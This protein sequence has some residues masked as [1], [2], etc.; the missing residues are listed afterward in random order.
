MPEIIIHE[1]S[2]EDV[3]K[4][5]LDPENFNR[6]ADDNTPPLSEFD[7]ERYFYNTPLNLTVKGAYVDGSIASI[8]IEHDGEIHFM[9]L[10]EFRP[11][12]HDIADRLLDTFSGEL[13]TKI[14]SCYPS[15]LHFTKKHGFVETGLDR[16]VFKKNGQ[17][18]DEYIL[19]RKLCQQQQH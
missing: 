5:F 1:P 12:A 7:M 2:K 6:S 19:T 4:V 15:T 9:L 17:L 13:Y 11:F 16:D 14:P 3:N 8:M 18:Y 10:K